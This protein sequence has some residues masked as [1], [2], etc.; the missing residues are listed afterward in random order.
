MSACRRTRGRRYSR[1]GSREI[2]QERCADNRSR[3][4]RRIGNARHAATL[5]GNPTET[6]PDGLS[7]V[8]PDWVRVLLD[9]PQEGLSVIVEDRPAALGFTPRTERSRSHGSE[10]ILETCDLLTKRGLAILSRREAAE[11]L[12]GPQRQR[13]SAVDASPSVELTCRLQSSAGKAPVPGTGVEQARDHSGMMKIRNIRILS[14]SLRITRSG[15][16]CNADGHRR[17]IG[18][19]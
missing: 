1:S 8:T 7:A 3:V 18:A 9:L 10:L 16:R 6:I 17:S 15:W 12:P 11:K 19:A 4:A 13:S 2:R 14:P 5:V